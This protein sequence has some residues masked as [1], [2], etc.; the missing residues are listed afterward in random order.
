MAI[1][2]NEIP[3]NI[4]VPFVYVEFDASQAN[5]GPFIQPYKILAIGQR[6][7]SGTK[8][9]G[10]LDVIS[11]ASQGAQYYGA[12][13]MLAKMIDKIRAA[14]KVTELQ[15]IALDDDGAAVAASG[16]ILFGGAPTAA[17]TVSVMIG[18][19][20]YRQ[21]VSTTDTPADIAT[22]LSATIQADPDR[23]VDVAP[24]G[25][26]PEQ[27][28]IGARNAGEA[29]N[30]I[31][32][33]V[34]YFSGEELPAGVTA[35]VTDLA[36]GTANPDVSTILASLPEDQFNIIAFPYT[37]AANLGELETEL[38]D[39]FG[40]I[41][42]NDG[43]A[44]IAKR[45]TFANLATLGNGENSQHYSIMGMAGPNSPWEWAASVAGEVALAGQA[46]PARPFQTL[47]L[48]DILAPSDA[49]MDADFGWTER[50]SLLEDGIATFR[51][52]AGGDVV[53]ERLVTTYKTNAFGGVDPSFRD[54]NTLLTLSYLRYDFRNF[55][56]TR[57][58]RHKLAN[59]GTR[60]GAGQ[61][62]IT[63]AI[64]KAEAIGRFAQWEEL[65]LVEDAEQFARDLLVE[66]D[67]Q[68][69]N[70]LNFLLPANIINQL[71]V[72]AAQIQFRL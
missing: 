72:V 41:R 20:R 14:N 45:D 60:F 57:Y 24:D 34:N 26:T 39:R 19:T 48:T 43:V 12:G 33:R 49:E 65:G 18:G 58:P 40:P 16:N 3:N 61:A 55:F 27:M 64:G 46:D 11:D 62:V 22:N 17:G 36:G 29:G 4:L 31:D 6:L 50:Q 1:S 30:E 7:T 9:A 42:Q 8:P 25:G 15:A 68:D 69:P 38:E 52:T 51:K 10:Q 63:P 59:D 37:D 66:R 21:A 32:V 71:R 54:V 28:N 44:I 35:V 67:S 5:Q 47:E 56:L 70:R 2:F 13:S 23:V 53:I